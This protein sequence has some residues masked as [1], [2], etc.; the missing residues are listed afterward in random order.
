[1]ATKEPFKSATQVA[2]RIP[3]ELA[4]FTAVVLGATGQELQR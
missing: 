3:G 1:V 2:W 4:S